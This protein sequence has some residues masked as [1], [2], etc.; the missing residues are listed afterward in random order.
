MSGHSRQSSL[1]RARKYSDSW[2]TG[3]GV[4][5]GGTR[6]ALRLVV[7]YRGWSRRELRRHHREVIEKL[8]RWSSS[9]AFA[10]TSAASARAGTSGPQAHGPGTGCRPRTTSRARTGRRDTRRHGVSRRWSDRAPNRADR[11]RRAPPGEAWRASGPAPRAGPEPPDHRASLR[12]RAR[13]CRSGCRHPGSG[14]AGG[15][16]DPLPDTRR[17]VAA[18]ERELAHQGVGERVEQRRRRRRGSRIKG[19]SFRASRHER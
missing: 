13:P 8:G 14:A 1:R 2:C 4:R 11:T 10:R 16:V 9:R 17:V 3:E 5:L 6:V 19:S 7:R 15:R 18:L 12:C